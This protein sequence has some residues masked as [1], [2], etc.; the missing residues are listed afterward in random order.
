MAEE[1]SQ[2]KSLA[3]K[4]WQDWVSV[5]AGVVL[6]ISPAWAAYGNGSGKVWA[7]IGGIVMACVALWSLASSASAASEWTQ[8]VV[9]VIVFILPWCVGAASVAG[10]WWMWILAVIT[11]IMAIWSMQAHKE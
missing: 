9:D 11:L 8:I 3:W 1:S 2:K 6:A 7:I 4:T 10:G 5:V